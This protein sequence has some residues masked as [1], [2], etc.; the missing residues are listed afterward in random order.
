MKKKN[1]VLNR[2]SFRFKRFSRD[3]F[4]VFN[5]ISKVVTIGVLAGCTLQS[6]HSQ[7][8]TSTEKVEI[9]TKQDTIVSDEL[10][11]IVIS[12]SK[13]NLPISLSAKLVTVITSTDIERQPIQS[14][15]DLLTHYSGID[16][17]QRGPHGV[18]SDISI[19]GGSFD[20]TAI[21][22]NGI[23]LT[24]PQ[25]GHYSLDIP[26]N[27]S[28][29]EQIEIVQG[30]SSLAY[31]AGAF[32]G[33]VNIITKQD[34]ESNFRAKA[35]GGMHSLFSAE[36]RGAIKAKRTTHKLSAGYRQ[37][38]GY[39]PNSDYKMMNILYQ[40][41][42]YTDGANI[43]FTAGFNSKAFGANTFYTPAFA[44]QFDDTQSIFFS[45]QGE[46]QGKLKFKPQIYFNRHYDKFQLIRGDE[47]NIPYNHH[48]SDVIGTNLVWQYASTLGV[49][50]FGSELRNE[51]I[52]SSVLGKP[53]DEAI[54]KYTHSDSRTNASIFAE[55]NL[56]YGNMTLSVGALLNHNTA[57]P[58]KYEFYP[59]VNTSYR[60]ENGISLFASWSK[61]TRMPTFTDLYY[62]TATHTG[63]SDLDA[64]KSESMDLGIKYRKNNINGFITTFYMKG[65]NLIDWVK[66]DTESLWQSSNHS[67]ID[68][69]GIEAGL[70]VNIQG[71]LGAK[72]P[73]Q[74]LSMGYMHLRQDMIETQFIS[75][76]TLNHLRHKVTASL[77]HNIIDGLNMS[78]H[79]RWQDRAGSY[80]KYVDQ[81]PG[82]RTSYKPFSIVDIKINYSI[83]RYNVFINT[84]N[85]FNS[86]HLDLGNL[87][88]AGFWMMAG[89]E[90]KW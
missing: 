74:S 2:K 78:W 61:S 47:T 50:S 33:G 19:R 72:Q 55:H 1:Q 75:N 83:D 87:P 41:R 38:N 4:S 18:Q 51:S 37:S 70:S 3:T 64:E 60:F 28:D 69:Y 17:Q 39:M 86:Q 11:E 80:I 26:I 6:A 43:D 5:S 14:I 54:G 90:Y 40:S 24:N 31:G 27:I 58:N 81:K 46:T 89:V 66:A 52:L 45:V 34:K 13:T 10:E 85:I 20:Q 8:V 44:N 32:S 35:E 63:N 88:Q 23:N 22:L 42:L 29:I 79:F 77:H 84:N 68:K 76:Y 25:T 48:R 57:I 56:I 21:L 15:E 9:T 49:T 65:R 36:A 62:T 7:S 30:P 71:I 59:S 12:A 67:K 16:I 53:L 82:E 73:L